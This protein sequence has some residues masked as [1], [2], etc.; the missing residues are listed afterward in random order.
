MAYY[1]HFT[2]GRPSCNLD[3]YAEAIRTAGIAGG[4]LLVL[5][6]AYGL[7]TIS[8]AAFEPFVSFDG[9]SVCDTFARAGV[10]V[11][12]RQQVNASV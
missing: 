3:L 1:T 6:E 11:A 2:V 9:A 4:D 5:P 10:D 8:S 12:F 7:E